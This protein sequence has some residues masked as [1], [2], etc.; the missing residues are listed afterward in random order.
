M[1]EI[2]R[3]KELLGIGESKINDLREITSTR[4]K[5]ILKEIK[6]ADQAVQAVEKKLQETERRIETSEE[7]IVNLRDNRNNLQVGNEKLKE[8][9]AKLNRETTDLKREVDNLR[10]KIGDYNS[11]LGQVQSRTTDQDSELK[12]VTNTADGL[13]REIERIRLSNQQ[14]FEEKQTGLQAMQ[15]SLQKIR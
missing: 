1:S 8:E 12:E 2:S 3:I 14:E 9:M 15:Q 13:Q 5:S 10:S 7:Q 6:V 11:Q 4:L